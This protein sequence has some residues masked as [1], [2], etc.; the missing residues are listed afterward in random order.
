MTNEAPQKIEAL[1]Q[2]ETTLNAKNVTKEPPTEQDFKK[3]FE[4]QRTSIAKFYD[5]QIASERAKLPAGETTN[6]TI[7]ALE[8]TKAVELQKYAEGS[9]S[10]Y[11]K[12]HALRQELVAAYAE[13]ERKQKEAAEIGTKA[14][15][16]SAGISVDAPPSAGED[17]AA[18]E[19]TPAVLPKSDTDAPFTLATHPSTGPLYFAPP[20][21]RS[22]LPSVA[23]SSEV[24]AP[25]TAPLADLAATP[26]KAP[27]PQLDSQMQSVF[28]KVFNNPAAQGK[29]VDG[30]DIDGQENVKYMRYGSELYK[31]VRV[32][33]PDP[34]NPKD[35]T[36]K[37]VVSRYDPVQK[38]WIPLQDNVSKFYTSLELADIIANLPDS[39][40][41]SITW[42][43]DF[44]FEYPSAQSLEFAKVHGILV[45]KGEDGEGYKT[46]DMATGKWMTWSEKAFALFTSLKLAIENVWV[47]GKEI[48]NPDFDASG[49]EY[50]RS[51]GKIFVRK[52]QDD[53]T[54]S[55]YEAYGGYKDRWGTLYNKDTWTGIKVPTPGESAYGAV[56]S[57]SDTSKSDKWLKA[58]DIDSGEGDRFDGHQ[59]YRHGMEVYMRAPD[60][61]YFKYNPDA[62]G[63]ENAKWQ[64]IDVFP[65]QENP[66]SLESSSAPAESLLKAKYQKGH[67]ILGVIVADSGVTLIE[68]LNS[69]DPTVATI[70]AG[71]SGFDKSK[72]VAAV[73]YFTS[74]EMD[75]LV[76]LENISNH[77]DQLTRFQAFIESQNTQILSEAESLIAR[78]MQQLGLAGRPENFAVISSAL[79][80]KGVDL[81]RDFSEAFD[82]FLDGSNSGGLIAA[83]E[84]FMSLNA[85]YAALENAP[86]REAASDVK[87][88][89]DGTVHYK[90][91]EEERRGTIGDL[92]PGAEAVTVNEKV[93]VKFGSEFYYANGTRAIVLDGYK[94]LPAGDA[95]KDQVTPLQEKFKEGKGLQDV[96]AQFTRK[97]VRAAEYAVKYTDELE[98]LLKTENPD[99]MKARELLQRAENE[100][101]RM[102]RRMEVQGVDSGSEPLVSVLSKAD[103]AMGRLTV[104]QTQYTKVFAPASVSGQ[105]LAGG[106]TGATPLDA[107]LGGDSGAGDAAPDAGTNPGARPRVAGGSAGAR[108]PGG[109]GRTQR[110]GAVK[111]GA[112]PEK[113]VEKTS[114]ARVAE[115]MDQTRKYAGIVQAIGEKITKNT[116][117][118]DDLPKLRIAIMAL[119]AA[120]KE[121]A[122]GHFEKVKDG[123]GLIQSLDAL[124]GTAPNPGPAERI[125]KNLE[126]INE[127]ISKISE[128]S[129][130]VEQMMQKIFGMNRERE[131][132]TF[133]QADAT[134][135]NKI[136]EDLNTMK[137]E[138]S[139]D[140]VTSKSEGRA[141][142]GKIEN[143][144]KLADLV[145]KG[146][147]VNPETGEEKV[148][149]LSP[150]QIA[151]EHARLKEAFPDAVSKFKEAM[152]S[153]LDLDRDDSQYS[154]K[155]LSAYARAFSGV[156]K[157]EKEIRAF[158]K[159]SG[160]TTISLECSGSAANF[161]PNEPLRTPEQWFNYA[162]HA[163]EGPTKFKQIH[164]AIIGTRIFPKYVEK[165]AAALDE[166]KDGSALKS[167]LLNADQDV[168]QL[169]G[170][171]ENS[172][173]AQFKTSISGSVQKLQEV[174]KE[175]KA[176]HFDSFGL[177]AALLRKIA[178]HIAVGEKLLAAV[179]KRREDLTKTPE[180]EPNPA[181]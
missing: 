180:P 151:A 79:E 17:A 19:G 144:I 181:E 133:D 44:Q 138:M 43:K 164:D 14:V 99:P 75:S 156:R 41:L 111:S 65:Y 163:D 24:P 134:E 158:L 33:V 155:V 105:S 141:L 30:K 71:N 117:E 148:T 34:T 178:S 157:V 52:K 140:A 45:A 147:Q 40:P 120:R 86:I 15:L 175:L 139:V 113:A 83:R 179:A 11:M 96:S 6:D 69:A 118:A 74:Q 115:L 78:V 95:Q 60:G 47:S 100:Y 12:L 165:Y 18:V 70:L 5:K 29:F 8:Q 123:N 145:L 55:S 137:K 66:S 160:Q 110:G 129:A 21:S 89:E 101:N 67:E 154:E 25:E 3:V 98:A 125:L 114:E 162:F 50:M 146:K 109:G 59:F 102:K 153:I 80:A 131:L 77:L 61:K 90:T 143:G 88:D 87:I 177:G 149:V 94:V 2:L 150:E 54:Y 124:L 57:L 97:A 85:L 63:D 82:Y 116:F 84:H 112:A 9:G 92:Y 26:E 46:F 64:Q 119:R 51:D 4:D 91:K 35:V 172:P 81:E 126:G 170:D 176:A 167:I 76:S 73:Q 93:A 23:G 48:G 32:E 31:K 58:T 13:F 20:E 132:G 53:G 49:Y 135:L 36:Y 42:K 136:L 56:L 122:D 38:D 168:T 62:Q 22:Y 161:N 169:S 173:L 72:I 130:A 68:L 16:A 106:D 174:Q 28:Q 39:N 108:V 166:S 27:Q 1:T 171:G 121:A 127:K 103:S 142:I 10:E 107:P 37:E 104:L 128:K 7:Q 159:G 152:G